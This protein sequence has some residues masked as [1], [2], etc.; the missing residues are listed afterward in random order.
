MSQNNAF[1]MV[2]EATISH[3]QCK[4]KYALLLAARSGALRADHWIP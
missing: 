4:E 1:A 2:I 3:M